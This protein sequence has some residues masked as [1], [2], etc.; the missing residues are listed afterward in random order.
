MNGNLTSG[1]NFTITHVID[2]QGL[3]DSIGVEMVVITTAE[4]KETVHEK[5][6]LE[7]VKKE[8][9]LYTFQLTTSP[10][11]AGS[12]KIAFRMYPKNKHLPYRQ[13]FAYVR[14]FV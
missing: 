9:N 7:V 14:W 13:D 1:T 6:P 5:F 10:D 8:G 11:L 12:F 3:E 2:A 4:G